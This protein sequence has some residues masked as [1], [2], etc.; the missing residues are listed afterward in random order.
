MQT[1]AIR[2]HETGGPDVLRWE[3]IDLPVPEADEVLVRHTAVGLN[4]ID[5]YIR[6]G[7]YK[8]NLPSGL[9]TE[10]AGIIEVTGSQVSHLEA[11]DRVAYATGP[12]GAYSQARVMPAQYLVKLP[13]AIEDTVAASIML[14]GLTVQYLLRQTFRVE[15]G[16]TILWHAAAGGVGLIAC[17][18]AKALG[19]RVIGTVSTPEKAA[20]AK[21][22][23]CDE[24]ILYNDEDFV[25]RVKE[26]TDGKGV[27][28]VYDSVGKA[29]F[30]G[31][32]DC[33]QRRGLFVTFGNASGPVPA[34]EPLLLNNK[35]S[36]YVTR[37]KLA[38]YATDHASLNTMA[39][40]LFDM[41]IEGK[42]KAAPRQTYALQD[43]GRAHDAL[44]SRQTTGSTV[45][46]P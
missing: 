26:L 39:Q 7:L 33:L 34:F 4:F 28:V 17:Q 35:G 42:I 15:A 19:A 45:L 29:T 5:T 38:D 8:T 16:M 27:P 23:G 20:L 46:L 6:S 2:F 24:V 43:A 37:P 14:Q 22:H 1:H 9:G 13:D 30:P 36:L 3:T 11:G 21:A 31:S 41:V 10:A 40:E 18:W 44:T 32:L 12:L 25:A